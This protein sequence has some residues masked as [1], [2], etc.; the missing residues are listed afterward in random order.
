MI[1]S[2]ATIFFKFQS[3]S[4]N[5]IALL[6]L[7]SNLTAL[8]SN[9][10]LLIPSSFYLLSFIVINFKFQSDSINT[11]ML[12]IMTYEIMSFKFQSD[13]INT[14]RHGYTGGVA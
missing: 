8:N 9:L 14:Q 5:T 12:I 6:T 13:S 11:C 7:V 4:I 10:I 3:D 1:L 2:D